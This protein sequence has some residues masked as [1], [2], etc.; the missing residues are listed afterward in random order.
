M[1]NRRIGRKRLYGI[2][3]KGRSVDLEA[4]AGIKDAIVS[5]TQHRQG[6]ELITEIQ[7]DLGTSEATILGGNADG[8]AMATSG[9]A[10][11]LTKLTVAKYGVITEIRAVLLEVPAGADTDIDIRTDATAEDQAGAVST[12]CIAGLTAIGEDTSKLYD[13]WTTLG[14]NGSSQHYLYICNGA[15]SSQAAMTAGKV[16]IYIHGFVV[17]ADK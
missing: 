2:E 8:A 16:V 13:T 9:A 17:P 11:H 3:K 4:G 5:A 12:A 6:Q 15:A 14:Q 7:V 1:G 10:A